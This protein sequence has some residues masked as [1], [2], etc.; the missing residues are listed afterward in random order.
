MESKD[1]FSKLSACRS[2]KAV[3][4]VVSVF[5]SVSIKSAGL[6]G[7]AKQRSPDIPEITLRYIHTRSNIEAQEGFRRLRACEDPL[8]VAKSL[9]NL[10]AL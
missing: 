2:S 6:K 8:D 5:E 1:Q 7:H 3:V 9:S 4:L 10:L